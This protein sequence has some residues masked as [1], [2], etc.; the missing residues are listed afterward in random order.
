MLRSDARRPALQW[1]AIVLMLIV[2]L[3]PAPA[4]ASPYSNITSYHVDI[5]VGE[6]SVYHVEETISMY[7]EPDSESHGMYRTMDLEPYVFFE[8]DGEFYARGYRV[9]LR[10]LKVQGD[11][12]DTEMEDGVLF[13]RIG[14]PDVLVDGEEVTYNISYDYD[15]GDDGYSG[16]DMFYFGIIGDEW[17]QSIDDVTFD[18]HMPAPF[19]TDDVGF[20]VG[21]FGAEGYDPGT[22]Q[23][24]INGTD[25]TGRYT[26]TLEP[27]EGIWI[28]IALPQG[29]FTGTRQVDPAAEAIL[30]TTAGIAAAMGVLYLLMRPRHKP[31]ITVEF[32]PP[33][34]LTSA[35]VGYVI[36]GITETRDVISLLIYWASRGYLK[37]VEIAAPAAADDE[38]RKKKP[39]SAG[40]VFVKLKD[41][42]TNAKEYEKLMFDKLFENGPRVS[43]NE[44]RYNFAQTISDTK[45]RID[46][47]FTE[48]DN[49]IFTPV[50]KIVSD[51]CSG[52]AALPPAL[53]AAVSGYYETYEVILAAFAGVF[54]F[55]FGYVF[56]AMTARLIFT[57]RSSLKQ[58]RRGS[59]IA[60]AAVLGTDYVLTFFGCF[61]VFGW[62]GLAVLGLSACLLLLA[63]FFRGRT[64]R[65]L[66][67]LGQILGLRRFIERA[68]KDRLEMLA[69]DDPS[70]FYDVLPY[71]YVLG[72]S[73][74]WARQFED[75]AVPPPSWY[76][77]SDMDNFTTGVFV[78]SIMQNLR[79]TESAMTAV[80]SES[81]T[82]SSGSGGGGGFSGGGFSGGGFGGG[83]GGRW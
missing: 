73:D 12:F 28:R 35:D 69:A 40:V 67:L 8:Q 29:Y 48:P 55:I 25:I 43:T 39:R 9:L 74:T 34:G 63:P 21:S 38:K 62:W 51:V 57:W 11:R 77:G 54:L 53:M 33:A 19:E 6:D 24:E 17:E 65:G 72:I 83:G 1:T 61:R 30:W 20:S 45:K 49:R 52:L 2:L 60:C 71:A 18:I 82:G 44:L 75:L 7:F 14:D 59:V 3:A 64:E 70:L 79:S 81:G 47:Q 80:R 50:S 16:F 27:Y 32:G 66:K 78:G 23:Y 4:G 15:P 41:L 36:D 10:N 37:I 46:H 26:S 68:E 13:L 31:V 76:Y 56:A 5:T 42:P 22:L 58:A